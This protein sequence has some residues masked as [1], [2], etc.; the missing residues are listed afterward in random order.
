MKDFSKITMPLARLT[1]KNAKFNRT[2]RCEEHFQLLK[3]LLTSAPVLT[4][5]SGDEGHA[6]Y[7]DYLYFTTVKEARVE[8]PYSLL[9]EGSRGIC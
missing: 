8:L 1:Q 7:R 9:G 4:L 6:V 2:D 3:G 5:P